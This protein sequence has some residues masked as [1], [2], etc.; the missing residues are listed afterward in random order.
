MS[1][2]GTCVTGCHFWHD[3]FSIWCSLK[4]KNRAWKVQRFLKSP[5]AIVFT[6]GKY[7]RWIAN[8]HPANGNRASRWELCFD[9]DNPIDAYLGFRT[10]MR[11]H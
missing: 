9:V 11:P 4:T 8:R 6:G 2:Q 7:P 3:R 5:N 1:S 10:D